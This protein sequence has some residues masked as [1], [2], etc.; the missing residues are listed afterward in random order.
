LLNALLPLLWSMNEAKAFWSLKVPWLFSVP[1]ANESALLLAAVLPLQVVV[2]FS[3][4][5]RPPEIALAPA[6]LSARA[7]SNCVVRCRSGCR[8]ASSRDRRR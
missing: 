6:P 1:A 8:R 7:P 2:P 3:S 4:T 5:V